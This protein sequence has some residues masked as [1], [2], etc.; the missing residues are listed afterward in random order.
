MKRSLVL[1]IITLLA[2]SIVA[3]ENEQ[4]ILPI[5]LAVTEISQSTERT[6]QNTEPTPLGKTDFDEWLIIVLSTVA[7]AGTIFTILSIQ[8]NTKQQAINKKF[9]EQILTD[10]IRHLYRNKICIS[11]TAWKLKKEGFNK[12]YPSEEHIKKL[13]VLPED[14]RVER[15]NN[16]P[17]NYGDLHELE[18]KLRNFD[19]EVDVALE[20][21]KSSTIGQK[22]KE[23]DL[24]TLEFKSQYLTKEII[25]LMDKLDFKIAYVDSNT[26]KEM[27]VVITPENLKKYLSSISARFDNENEI[28]ASIDDI[29]ERKNN[30]RK[31]YYDIEFDLTDELNKDICGEYPKISL[32]KF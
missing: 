25:S 17:K 8:Q 5:D 21:L 7:A 6:S 30:N 4:D 19:I 22:V 24:D 3:S 11:A 18:L 1:F 32:I 20:H 31:N 10:L 14:L 23:R 26:K 13:K 9:Q 28:Y 15:F 2:S 16:T 29:P 12:Y 27:K